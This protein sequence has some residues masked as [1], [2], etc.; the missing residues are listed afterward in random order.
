MNLSNQPAQMSTRAQSIFRR[1]YSRPTNEEATLFEDFDE[2]LDRVIGHQRWLWEQAKGKKLSA[3]EYAELE[4]LRTLMA[5]RECLLAG[6]TLWLGGTE[7]TKK[8]PATNFNCSFARI[9]TVSDAVDAYWLLMLGCGVGFEPITGTLS[10]FA[11]PMEIEVI[12][13]ERTT[14]G[15]PYN[16]E[17]ARDGVWHIMVGDSAEAWCKAFGKVLAGKERA[18]K[19]IL[20]FSQIRPAGERLR[21]YGW[22]SSGDTTIGPAFEAICRIMNKK[23]GQLLTRMDILDVMNW[24]GTTLSSRR[25]AEIALVPH[26][27]PEWEAFATAKDQFW[28]ENPQRNQSNNSLLFYQKPTQAELEKI[29]KLMVDSGGSEPGFI[30]AQSALKRA[31]WFKGVNPCVP[32]STPILTKE[33]YFPIKDLV[34]SEVEVWNGRK[35]SPTTPFSTGVN[36][37]VTVHLDDG[38]SLTCTPYHEFIVGEREGRLQAQNLL[39]GTKLSKFEM[40]VVEGSEEMEVDP[41]SQ[42]IYAAEGNAEWDFSWIY[43]PKYSVLPF[44]RGT[45]SESGRP[46]CMK[47]H[48]GKML[49]KNYVPVNAKVNQALAWLAGVLDGDGCVL[50]NPNS[51]MLQ[52]SSVDLEFL[53]QIRLMLTRLGV[54]AK[55]SEMHPAGFRSLP[56]GKGGSA[57]Y[58]CQ[59]SYRLLINATDTAKLYELGLPLGRLTIIKTSP[60][61]DARRF[62]RVLRV[63]ELDEEEETFCF[64]EESNHSGT[65]AGIVTGQCAEILLGN[66]SFCNL[67][68]VDLAKFNGRWDALYRAVYIVARANYRQTCV[69]LRDGILQHTWHELNQ[70]LRL[71]GVG[72]TGIVRWECL[73]DDSALALLRQQAHAGAHSMADQLGLPRSK[74]ITTVKPSGTLS[75]LMDTTE[76]AHKPLGRYIFNNVNFSNHD[77]LLDLFREAGYKVWANPLSKDGT[78]VTFPQ[79]W[80]DVS[81]NEE[82]LNGETAVEQLERYRWLQESWCDQ[83]VSITISYD[84]TEVPAIIAWLQEHWDSYVGVSFLFRT[85]PSKSAEDLGYAYIPQECVSKEVFEEYTKQLRPVKFQREDTMLELDVEDCATGTCPV[86]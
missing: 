55:I 85:D 9:E 45:I 66:K 49:P 43:E 84:A 42:G 41:Y 27:D 69:D 80:P 78:L 62:V 26:G 68:E 6:R 32:G 5:N 20:D 2:M 35:F 86:R 16:A 67:V 60:Q 23:A 21:G 24:I 19:I 10:G 46:G 44:L 13:S 52:L 22:I 17:W 18:E 34:G 48:H 1:T 47:W 53:L 30:N 76:G 64:T 58:W 25:S 38:T 71:T 63:E 51:S 75:K 57:A 83:N 11:A 59:T 28:R 70:F 73:G 65:F 12:R 56:D 37:L 31:P 14:K 33:G 81:F 72:L 77:P 54:Q 4:E 36:P 82:G 15:N 61:R 29:F 74:N 3:R 8:R 79:A 40:P 7:L 50:E 39:P